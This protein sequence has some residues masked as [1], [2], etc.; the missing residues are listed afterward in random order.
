VVGKV[1]N[2]FYNVA[3]ALQH[4]RMVI[5]VG[6]FRRF[7]DELLAFIRGGE[8]DGKP[9]AADPIVRNKVASLATE[10]E[11][12]YGLYWQTAW[13]IDKGRSL[14][15]EGSCLKLFASELSVLISKVTMD[16]LGP[17]GLLERGSTWAY[18]DGRPATG[19]LSS[20]SGPIGAGASEIQ[21]TIIATRGLG[22]PR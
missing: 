13:A 15:T 14:E 1:N 16:I 2:G 11:A 3:I 22:L 6:A 20:I 7:M 5:A 10:V 8:R 21:R 9:L 18:M 12:L 17:R 4:E 19:Y